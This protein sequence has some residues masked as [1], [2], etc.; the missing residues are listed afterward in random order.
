[1]SNIYFLSLK[2]FSKFKKF[3]SRSV[4]GELQLTRYHLI[5]KLIVAIYKSEVWEKN[6]VWLFYYLDFK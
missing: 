1:M 4:F 2:Q 6:C 5:F 3:V